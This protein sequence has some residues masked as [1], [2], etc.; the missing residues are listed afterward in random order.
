MVFYVKKNYT[1][2]LEI[3]TPFLI[4]V[5]RTELENQLYDT[6]S[7][8]IIVKRQEYLLERAVRRTQPELLKCV[9]L[10]P[11]LDL[12]SQISLIT[13]RKTSS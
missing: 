9:A 6:F 5:D 4:A 10:V 1:A 3:N 13:N 8:Q 7:G 12:K 2:N 11:V